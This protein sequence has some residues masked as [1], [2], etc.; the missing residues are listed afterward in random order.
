MSLVG[1]GY[2]I[3][4]VRNCENGDPDRI[5][6]LAKKSDLSH[7]IVK[8]ADGAFPYNIDL[9]RGIDYAKPAIKK[10]RA[11]NIEVWG[12]QYIYGNYPDQEAEIAVARTLELGLDGFVINAEKEYQSSDKATAASRYMNILRSNL[13]SMPIALSSYRYPSYHHKFPWTNFLDRCDY[14]MPQVYWMQSHNNAG[15]QLKRSVNEYTT[16]LPYRPIIP[17]GPTFKEHGWIPYQAEVTEFMN[18][19]KK[20][21]LPAVNFWYWEGCRRDMPQF[22]ELVKEYEYSS[23][24]EKASAPHSYIDAVNS[25]D[26][27]KVVALYSDN[28]V[29]IRS[30]SAV[31]GKEA[32]R[33]W[34]ASLM[35]EYANCTF[36]LLSESQ[37]GNVYSFQLQVSDGSGIHLEGRDS[38]GLVDKK[39]GY[40]YSFV[41][42]GTIQV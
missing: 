12:W 6:S 25:A 20:L 32:I 36:K 14:S 21:N 38:I 13:G 34:I 40:H 19:A 2:Y 30:G 7:V 18:V 39:I 4:I 5:A 27:D 28:A 24:D 22:W 33:Q 26:P 3:W 16:R 15:E 23:S 17:T 8:V 11:Q 37:T 1:K 31:Q 10:L 9:D 42:K 41:K 29:Q 35:E